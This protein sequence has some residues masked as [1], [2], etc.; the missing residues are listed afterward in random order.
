M[1]SLQRSYKDSG[2]HCLEKCLAFSRLSA[3][4]R[5]CLLFLK[6]I[7]LFTPEAVANQMSLPQYI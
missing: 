5:N 7:H 1:H 2:R 3:K 6:R 4:V